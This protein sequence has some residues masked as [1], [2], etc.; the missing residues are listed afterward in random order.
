MS[1]A[2]LNRRVTHKGAVARGN[3]AYLLREALG[4]LAEGVQMGDQIGEIL[5]GEPLA[6]IAGHNS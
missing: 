6:I 1:P 5:R 3:D 4:C 2:R